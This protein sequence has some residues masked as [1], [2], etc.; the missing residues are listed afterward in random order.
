MKQNLIQKID[1]FNNSPKGKI[2]KSI[3]LLFFSIVMVITATFAWFFSNVSTT[4]G[5]MSVTVSSSVSFAEY[6]AFYIDDLDTKEVIK[7]D[8]MSMN[9][10]STLSVSL[11]PYDVTF[12][13]VNQ[14]APVVVRIELYNIEAEHIP[15]GAQ[16]KT[17]NVT[18]SRDAS[19]DT[20]TSTNLCGIFSSIGQFGCYTASGLALDATN[21][22]VYDT[23]VAQYRADNSPCKFTTV[24]N[25][26]YTK[27]TSLD[28]SVLY[29]AGDFKTNNSGDACLVVY[30]VFD[31]NVELTE[32]YIDQQSSSG[33][34]ANE[35]DQRIS[36]ANDLS[37]MNIYF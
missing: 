11:L 4:S 21:Q 26:T 14:Y 34:G 28:M 1:K 20:G 30:L 6:S 22:T 19:L 35:F 12:T 16:Q 25:E 17:L 27:T 33:S 9:D 3:F 15:T 32:L 2:V 8:T 5:G 23:I 13:S 24:T 29:G 37:T 36:V 10:D 31:Y 18:L 7:T